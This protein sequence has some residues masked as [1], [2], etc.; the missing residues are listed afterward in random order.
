M[1]IKRLACFISQA[2]VFPHFFFLLFSK[3]ASFLFSGDTCEAIVMYDGDRK[4]SSPHAVSAPAPV[5]PVAEEETP[6]PIVTPP[7]KPTP[8]PS[9]GSLYLAFSLFVHFPFLFHEHAMQKTLD[10]DRVC[11]YRCSSSR[12]HHNADAELLSSLNHWY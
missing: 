2:D 11:S 1:N 5:H 4:S 8:Q 9:E 12:W 7:S 3:L 6:K 10:Q